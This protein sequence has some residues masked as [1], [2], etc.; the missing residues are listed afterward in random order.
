MEQK[1]KK[2]SVKRIIRKNLPSFRIKNQRKK[3]EK[4]SEGSDS[5]RNVDVNYHT[6]T[7][8]SGSRV[9]GPSSGRAGSLNGFTL[10]PGYPCDVIE[11]VHSVCL[12]RWG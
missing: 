8:T 7:V 5:Y 2:N 3:R 6:V 11:H 9:A 12:L 10:V 1:E 4:E